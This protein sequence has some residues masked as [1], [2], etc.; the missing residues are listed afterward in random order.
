MGDVTYNIHAHTMGKNDDSAIISDFEILVPRCSALS[1][2]CYG[3]RSLAVFT[4]ASVRPKNS[5]ER[6]ET[7]IKNS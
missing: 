4:G 3:E 7:C 6:A 5:S 1:T 2:L